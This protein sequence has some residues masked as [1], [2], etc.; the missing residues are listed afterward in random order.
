[1]GETGASQVVIV[2]LLAAPLREEMVVIKTRIIVVDHITVM[3]EREAG[4]SPGGEEPV[5][6]QAAP[7]LEAQ[8][9]P[10]MTSTFC[11]RPTVMGAVVVTYMALMSYVAMQ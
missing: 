7:R 4:Y 1:M 3:V 9:G 6:F 11:C 8:A 5:V 2:V 10:E